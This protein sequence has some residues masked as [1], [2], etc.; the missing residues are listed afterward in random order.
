[1]QRLPSIECRIGLGWPDLGHMHGGGV[2]G[3]LESGFGIPTSNRS[4]SAIYGWIY[5]GFFHTANLIIAFSM[6][7]AVEIY[8]R[9]GKFIRG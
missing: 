6:V 5:F 7:M 2:Y 3:A 4:F 1:M 8:P 9:L